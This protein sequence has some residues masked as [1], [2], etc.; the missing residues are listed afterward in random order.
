MQEARR[1]LPVVDDP[2]TGPFFAGAA[3]GEL[4]IRVCSCGEVSHL[5]VARCSRCG[6]FDGSWEKVSGR[7]RVSSWT[8]IEQQVHESFLAPYTV[9]LVELEDRAGVRLLGHLVGTPELREG[10][11]MH[12]VFERLADDTFIPQWVP[13]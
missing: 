7:A 8:V 1:V 5:P 12:V 2:D 3:R 9:V 6:S 13:D 11:L 10:Q 4:V